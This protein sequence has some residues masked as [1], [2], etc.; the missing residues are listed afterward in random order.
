METVIGVFKAF[1][2]AYL[3]VCAICIFSG[4]YFTRMRRKK[5]ELAKATATKESDS[6]K[7][8]GE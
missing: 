6:S 3:G 4:L 8:S 1:G 7:T 2:V 5:T